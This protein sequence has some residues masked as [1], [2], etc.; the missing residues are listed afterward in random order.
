MQITKNRLL[1][2]SLHTSFIA[3]N[4]NKYANYEYQKQGQILVC[5]FFYFSCLY[6]CSNCLELY[7]FCLKY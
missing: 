7:M 3:Y 6:Y 2:Y 1:S 5:F 4:D